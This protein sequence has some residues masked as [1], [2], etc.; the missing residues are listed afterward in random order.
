MFTIA[1]LLFALTLAAQAP[2]HPHQGAPK[3]S[4]S[5][6]YDDLKWE[7]MVPELG[8]DSPQ[9][10]ILRV[11]PKTQATQLLIRIPRQIHVPMHWHSANETHTV[12]KGTFVF[13]HEGARHELGPGGFNY[14]PARMHHQAWASDDALVFITVDAGWD[15]NWVSGPPTRSNLGK[16]PPTR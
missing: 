2:A 11:D 7:I 4:A 3:T 8:A 5:T 16:R 10:A 15:V 9:A 13:E 14:L 6:A 12:I 1:S